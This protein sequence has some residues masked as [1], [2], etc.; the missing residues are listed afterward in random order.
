MAGTAVLR[1]ASA[2]GVR[3]A[4]RVLAVQVAAGTLV[5][6]CTA[7]HVKPGAFPNVALATTT[8]SST[9]DFSTVALGSVAGRQMVPN[10]PIGPGTASLQ[11]TVTGPAG[12]VAGA[13]VHVE[14]IVD[15]YIGSA[16]VA[17]ASDGSWALHNIFGGQYRVRA[18]RAPDLALTQPQVLYLAATDTKSLDLQLGSYGGIEVAPALA[19][20]PPIIGEPAQ[21]VVEVT[22]DS[23]GNDGVVRAAAKAGATVQLFG[24]GRWNVDGP[25]TEVV[26]SQGITSWKLTCE[27]EGPQPLSVVINS[28]DVF[29]LNLAACVPVPPTTTTT[30]TNVAG[31]ETTTT[32]G[33]GHRTTTTSAPTTTTGG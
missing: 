21:L 12:P 2:G 3:G 20:N 7:G 32:R 15:G 6:A 1:E 26:N 17:S 18:W 4:V 23:V 10:V 33:H 8:T 25:L 30:T 19:P 27:Q 13:D 9:V 22:T 28:A 14:R 5:A 24:Q 11:G 29:P 31:G 16:D